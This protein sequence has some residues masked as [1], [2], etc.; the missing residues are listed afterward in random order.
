MFGEIHNVS[1]IVTGALKK[2]KKFKLNYLWAN[3][4]KIVGKQLAKKSYVMYIDN[5]KIYIGVESSIWAQHYNQMKKEILNNINHFL[6]E[7]IFTDLVIRVKKL[8]DYLLMKNNEAESLFDIEKESLTENEFLKI[9][10]ISQDINDEIKDKIKNIMV[11]SKKREKSLQ[12]IGKK[13]CTR[14][15]SIFISESKVCV[16]CEN[17]LHKEKRAVLYKLLKKYPL[18]DFN[19]V[20]KKM[21][22]LRN[23]EFEDIKENL[24]KRLNMEMMRYLKNEELEKFKE[25]ARIY[26]RLNSGIKSDIEIEKR[27]KNYLLRIIE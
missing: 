8:P 20:S 12:K 9:N 16:N 2:S 6:K 18:L 3:W 14:C 10:K 21:P 4:D 13:R 1:D 26:F 23:E 27:I 25:I 7:N 17:D 5:N 15:G 22:D 24:K 19:E 11:L